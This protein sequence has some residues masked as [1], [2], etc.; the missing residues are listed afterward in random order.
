MI[1]LNPSEYRKQKYIEFKKPFFIDFL[2]WLR[3]ALTI[4]LLMLL[5]ATC[6]DSHCFLQ[7]ISSQYGN[8]T[9]SMYRGERRFEVSYIFR[10][11]EEIK[12]CTFASQEELKNGMEVIVHDWDIF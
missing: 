3:E 7:I 1:W 11:T 4:L 12:D 5:K 9:S 6:N 10:T 8:R 2:E